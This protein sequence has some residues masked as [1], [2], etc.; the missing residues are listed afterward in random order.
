MIKRGFTLTEVVVVIIYIAIFTALLYPAVQHF[1]EKASIRAKCHDDD[2]G[3]IIE[4]KLGP[5]GIIKCT[6]EDFYQV[7]TI[8]GATLNWDKE[9]I[10]GFVDGN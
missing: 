5:R 1:R 7:E 3:K 8:D 2:K 9:Y 4:H 10:R 6:C